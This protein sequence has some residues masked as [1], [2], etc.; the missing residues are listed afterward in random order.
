MQNPSSFASPNWVPLV[1]RV[2]VTVTFHLWKW[3]VH[4][5]W[6]PFPGVP[7]RLCD[8]PPLLPSLLPSRFRDARKGKKEDLLCEV[9]KLEKALG[10][11]G[12][13][14]LRVA[15]Q[16]WTREPCD[17]ALCL[18]LSM[19]RPIGPRLRGVHSLS[20][21]RGSWEIVVFWTHQAQ[22]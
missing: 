22:R 1:F 12:D 11:Q 18:G 5:P 15:L 3:V 9:E 14:E 19:D 10:P 13:E 7:L 8:L 17:R 2:L 4:S 16:D 21:H 20:Q 6:C